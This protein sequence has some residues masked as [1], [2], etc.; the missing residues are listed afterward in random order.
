MTLRT[1]YLL[2]MATPG[3][4]MSGALA[5]FILLAIVL[6]SRAELHFIVADVRSEVITNWV[7]KVDEAY[8]IR[9]GIPN[10]TPTRT[11]YQLGTVLSNRIVTFMF[12]GSLTNTTISSVEIMRLRRDYTE[13]TVRDYGEVRKLTEVF[14]LGVTFTNFMPTMTNTHTWKAIF[15]LERVLKFKE[16]QTTNLIR[17]VLLH[18]NSFVTVTITNSHSIRVLRIPT[19]GVMTYQIPLLIS[20]MK[21]NLYTMTLTNGTGV[22]I[23]VSNNVYRLGFKIIEMTVK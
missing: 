22:T 16:R 9:I 12:F 13:R 15:D 14:D 17:P 7:D 3:L 6:P 2:R 20:E 23:T 11:T 10:Y 19:N 5:M 1:S 4:L 8:G 18:T 21:T